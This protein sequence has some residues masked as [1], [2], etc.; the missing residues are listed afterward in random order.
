M[1][2]T[3]AK[4]TH[5]VAAGL[6]LLVL[7]GGASLQPQPNAEH[8]VAD[9]ADVGSIDAIMSAWYDSIA[10]EPGEPRQWDRYKGL[11]VPDGRLVMVRPDGVGGTK[12][13][14]MTVDNFIDGNRRYMEQAG[15]ADT[16]IARTVEQ[17]GSIAQVF[18]TYASRR[19]AADDE[20]YARGINSLQLTFDGGRWWIV[21]VMWDQER[22]DNPIPAKYLSK[23]NK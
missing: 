11:F 15:F 23:P 20:P 4:P 2:R 8:P 9:P 3:H 22:E 21:S 16:E 6:V 10:G 19:S 17:F 14:T 1:K 7:L 5:I 18:S 13:G 12:I